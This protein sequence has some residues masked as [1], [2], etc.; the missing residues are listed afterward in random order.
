LKGEEDVQHD[1]DQNYTFIDEFLKEVVENS[2]LYESNQETGYDFWTSEH[3]IHASISINNTLH[4][5]CMSLLFFCQKDIT[6]AFSM[7]AQILVYEAKDGK[8]YLLIVLEEQM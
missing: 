1:A 3:N 6:S 5:K 2:N 8:S 4:Y 7:V